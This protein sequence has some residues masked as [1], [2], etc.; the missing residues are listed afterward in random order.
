MLALLG[1]PQVQSDNS[2]K[3]RASHS[4]RFLKND[5]NAHSKLWGCKHNDTRGNRIKYF[6]EKHNLCYF[7]DKTPTHLDPRVRTTSAIDLSLCHSSIYLDISWRVGE[8]LNG[9]DHFP[10]F[11]DH[12][13]STPHYK[14][15]KWKLHRANWKLYHQLC[16]ETTTQSI[17]GADDPVDKFSQNILDI[18]EKCIPK[19]SADPNRPHLPWFSKECKLAIKEKRKALDFFRKHPTHTNMLQYKQA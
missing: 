2:L 17:T 1:C 13:L 10:I 6:I 4:R 7:N 18:A 16:E 15:P 5:F 9:S 19:S 12:S 8:D 3:D 11:L 14:I